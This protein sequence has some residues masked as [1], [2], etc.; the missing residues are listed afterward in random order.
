M[1]SH[2]AGTVAGSI[3]SPRQIDK[4]RKQSIAEI[5]AGDQVSQHIKG[6]KVHTM[7]SLELDADHE[8]AMTVPLCNATDEQLLAEVA[9]RKLDIHANIT[10]V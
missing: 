10:Q 2:S 1:N 3:N 4:M 6:I 5:K 8:A 7:V 9:R